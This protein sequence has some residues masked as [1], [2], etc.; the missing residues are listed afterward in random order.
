[1]SIEKLERFCTQAELARIMGV[2]R[3][4]LSKQLKPL[5]LLVA[6]GKTIPL[7]HWSNNLLASVSVNTAPNPSPI[8]RAE[9]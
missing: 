8:S 7:Y 9:L 5:A 3:R 6:G 4:S 2:D 1:M